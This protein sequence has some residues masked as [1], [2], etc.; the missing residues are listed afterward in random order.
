M[1]VCVHVRKREVMIWIRT[2][3][4]MM[5]RTNGQVCGNQKGA[6]KGSTGEG[7]E[8]RVGTCAFRGLRG[9][10]EFEEEIA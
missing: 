8:E 7:Q 6:G 5:Q 9:D 3:L 1:A 4:S 2:K 10:D